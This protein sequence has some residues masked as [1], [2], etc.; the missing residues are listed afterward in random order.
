MHR[1][2]S[3]FRWH[4][5]ALIL[6]MLC[7][8]E[9][10]QGAAENVPPFDVDKF[11]RGPDHKDFPWEVRLSWPTRTL[12]QRY[13]VEIIALIKDESLKDS[14]KRRDLHFVLKAATADNHWVPGGV[15]THIQVQ[16]LVTSGD[17]Q[18][19]GNI[20]LRPGR[21]TIAVIVYDAIHEQ[22]NIVRK[23]VKVPGLKPE[24]LPELDRDLPDIEYVLEEAPQYVSTW[25]SDRGRWLPVNNKRYL[26]IDILAYIS[27]LGFHE[28]LERR[29]LQNILQLSSVFSRLK[30]RSG[31]VRISIL[32]PLRM[33]TYFDRENAAGFNWR[34]ALEAITK[35]DRATISAGL[36]RSQTPAG[37][38]AD[39]LQKIVN[40]ESC[41]PGVESPFKIIVIVS[42][43]LR[44]PKHTR[45]PQVIPSNPASTRSFYFY[46][47]DDYLPMMLKPIKRRNV[48]VIWPVPRSFR[49]ELASLI[50]SFEKLE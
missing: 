31:S 47:G 23:H 12:E 28:E 50:S 17:I 34:H 21:Y 10:A 4:R 44:F 11:L 38:L 32:D 13:S 19:R 24:P 22:G 36:L 2:K 35:Q 49:K 27:G 42:C 40:D 45:I 30:P 41:T 33:Q 7:G 37:L 20:Y 1:M 16:S 39:Q 46:T 15:Y 43:G 8:G 48:T 26:C 9:I 6:G 25:L 14:T 3:L 5:L 29:W 18:V